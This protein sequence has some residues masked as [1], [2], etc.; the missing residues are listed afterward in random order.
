[1]I[2]P[3][4]RLRLFRNAR[5]LH[6]QAATVSALLALLFCLLLQMPAFA[7]A[8]PTPLVI[9]S[10]SGEQVFTI[11]VA[12]TPEEQRRGLM[13]RRSLAPD[14]GML[15]PHAPPRQAHFWMRNTYISLDLLF[16]GPDGRIESIRA[17]AIPHDETP[18]SSRGDVIAVLEILAG[19]AA[20]RGIATG[21]RVRHPALP[22]PQGSDRP[23]GGRS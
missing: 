22:L 4:P 14:A 2:S 20:R 7:A 16:I 8:D 15:F 3:D 13:F 19:E 11:E 21:D 12:A 17:D 18:L 6:R 10:A 23:G 5:S 9:E 1:V